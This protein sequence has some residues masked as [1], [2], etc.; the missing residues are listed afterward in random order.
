[1]AAS[2]PRKPRRGKGRHRKPST[3]DASNYAQLLGIGAVGVGLAA[4]LAGGQATASASTGASSNSASA[5]KSPSA[6]P[7]RGN[8][9]P[10][11]KAVSGRPGS[12]LPV[13]PATTRATAKRSALD[14]EIAPA[15][16]HSARIV[17]AP[18]ASTKAAGATKTASASDAPLGSPAQFIATLN[19]ILDQ[20][21]GWPEPPT[22]TFVTPAN[23]TLEQALDAHTATIDFFYA[24]PTP[25]TRWMRDLMSIVH[26][27]LQPIDPA[28]TFGDGLNVFGSF[29]NRIV[30]PYKIKSPQN[31]TLT[32]AQVA[33][34]AVGALV[35]V[36]DELLAGDFNPEHWRD[37]ATE[38][39]T[40]GATDPGSILNMT[41]AT[42]AT[43]NFF[44]LIAYVALVACYDRYKWV[45]LNHLPTSNNTQ[46]GQLL[47]VVSGN[48][49]ATDADE[50]PLIYTYSQPTNG[51]VVVNADGSWVYTRT[52]NLLADDTDSFD[53]TID[54]T[55]G[56]ALDL[57]LSHP[58]APNGHTV[59]V[60]ITVNYDGSLSI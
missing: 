27:F 41:F 16:G 38:G 35:K 5:G 29:L 3:F 46:T 17:S 2:S 34:A 51:I 47:L 45:A 20:L 60:T 50:D 33:A 28:Y 40:A 11:P 8:Q 54:D 31:L 57:G 22:F 52:S 49:N 56:Q 59:T 48:V 18:A 36:L 39:G 30:P 1:M 32:K 44:S 9:P 55:A 37:A 6:G 10:A 43:P 13:A 58:Y 21:K 7:A 26:L 19:A 42:G 4:A 53:V 24:H 12:K 15:T 23:Y 25:A 14:A